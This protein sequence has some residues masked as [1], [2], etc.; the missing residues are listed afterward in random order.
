L[1]KA[2]NLERYP[3]AFVLICCRLDKKSELFILVYRCW[4]V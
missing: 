3:V 4:S 1:R 2:A